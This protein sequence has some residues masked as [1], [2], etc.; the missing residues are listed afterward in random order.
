MK[1]R[2]VIE[3]LDRATAP[4]RQI[5]LAM[6][7][8]SHASAGLRLATERIGGLAAS[9]ARYA[10]IAGSAAAVTGGAFLGSVIRTSAKFEDFQAVLETTE[11]SAEKAR[12]ALAWVSNFAT[13]TPYE[14]DETTQAFVRLRAYGLDP[15]RGMLRT[16]GDA[17]S[18]LSKP[19]LQAVEA[20]A[21]AVTGENERLK[22]FGITAS[23]RRNEITY[24][25]TQDGK[26][27]TKTVDAS[28]KAMIASTIEAIFNSRYAGAMER[29]S[30]TFN[31]MTSNLADSWTR[32]QQQVGEAGP[33]AAAKGFLGGLLG[34]LDGNS[35][36]SKR[37][38]GIMGGEMTR[39]INLAV[40]AIRDLVAEQG[41]AE[42]FA[43]NVGS[44][45]S[46]AAGAF[47]GFVG[48]VNAAAT[49]LRSLQ[50]GGLVPKGMGTA[51]FWAGNGPAFT[52]PKK[53]MA[54][55]ALDALGVPDDSWFG[56][57]VI[58]REKIAEPMGPNLPK[59]T[60]PIASNVAPS[61]A[62]AAGRA[63]APVA[64]QVGGQVEIT[65]KSDRPVAVDQASSVNSRV[66]IKV[67]R[68]GPAMQTGQ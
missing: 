18:A 1:V 27:L 30:K 13:T 12:S 66:P 37:L 45:I 56:R 34:A 46:A 38:A 24:A 16:L 54:G 52:A 11:G 10:A 64:T 58:G 68:L 44:A 20:M 35:A 17:S 49:G 31:G 53:G 32:F 33:F 63:T 57:N 28:N 6:G 3:A 14:L 22:E 67:K 19:I 62:V 43:R 4:L 59:P 36:A 29:R 2:L 61:A 39:G 21:D 25:W 23:K 65:I 8:V 47:S 5:G 7:G 50:D 41:G 40:G 55:A 15:T 51:D 60:A 48:A 42:G 9:T 26:T